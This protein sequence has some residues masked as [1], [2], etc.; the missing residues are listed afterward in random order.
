[1]KRAAA[2][3]LAGYLLATGGWALVQLVRGAEPEL[4]WLGLVLAALAPFARLG[5]ELTSRE[6]PPRPSVGYTAL[7]GLG[8]A[9]TMTLSWKHG[10]AAGTLHLWAGAAFIGWVVYLRLL[11]PGLESAARG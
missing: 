8:L 10:P 1:V 5:I 3:L 11:R 2:W 9:I 4:S 7:S 6:L